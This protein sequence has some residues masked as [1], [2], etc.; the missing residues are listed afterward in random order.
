[1]AATTGRRTL[2]G[3][4][5]AGVAALGVAAISPVGIAGAQDSTDHP[6]AARATS[7]ERPRRGEIVG[8]VLDGLVAD[9]TIDQAQADAIA[10]AF[11]VKTDELREQFGKGGGGLH[12]HRGEALNVAATALGMEPEALKDALKDGQTLAQVAATQGVDVQALTDALVALGNAR[13]DAAVADGR[14][15]AA[16]AEERKAQLVE[17]ITERV[18]TPR[19]R[20][21]RE[22]LR[23]RV[24][25]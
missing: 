13:I 18:N 14:L 1:M 15:D 10:E 17:R 20:R 3:I 7:E 16:K 23:D 19:E 12:G 6:V 11:R 25:D 9:G 4:T 8:E 2:A 21:G 22:R 5:L 24:G